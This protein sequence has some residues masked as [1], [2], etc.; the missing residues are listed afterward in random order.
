MELYK[1]K[2]NE[3]GIGV[4]ALRENSLWSILNKGIAVWTMFYPKDERDEE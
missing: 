2:L 1:G 3:I 4:E